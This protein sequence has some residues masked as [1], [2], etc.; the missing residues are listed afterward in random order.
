MTEPID[1]D[2]LQR[3]VEADLARS[4]GAPVH[5]LRPVPK[6]V[7]ERLDLLERPWR[8]EMPPPKQ[9]ASKY[10]AIGPGRPTLLVAPPGSG[11]GWT[12]FAVAI[13]VA[14]GQGLGELGNPDAK[15]GVLWLDYEEGDHEMHRR[16]ALLSAGCGVSPQEL[17]AFRSMSH[18]PQLTDTGFR[19]ALIPR[20]AGV[21]LCVVD[22]LTACWQVESR[23]DGSAA[24]PLVAMTELS[25]R[26]GCSFLVLYHPR[27]TSNEPDKGLEQEKVLGS[28]SLIGSAQSIWIGEPTHKNRCLWRHSKCN[29]AEKS[30]PFT[31]AWFWDHDTNGIRYAAERVG[32]KTAPSRDSVQAKREKDQVDGATRCRDAV[33]AALVKSGPEG[34]TARSLVGTGLGFGHHKLQCALEALE[35][36]GQVTKHQWGRGGGM[37][38]VLQAG[39]TTTVPVT[40][41]PETEGT[42]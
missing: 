38:Y 36:D 29:G 18:P 1:V 40:T 7:S 35:A 14:L 42:Q 32:E 15:G 24:A 33:M 28:Q 23:N 13:S 26:T 17:A 4:N 21:R 5:Q 10:L 39:R 37:R 20:L 41:V 6:S 27:K 25:E 9:W 11:K 22:T 3:K 30:D 16:E 31:F 8:G 19:N 12:A 34:L 2:A